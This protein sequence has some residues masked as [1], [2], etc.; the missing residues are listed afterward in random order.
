MQRIRFVPAT[1]SC[2]GEAANSLDRRWRGIPTICV[3]NLNKDWLHLLIEVQAPHGI[4][5]FRAMTAE[6]STQGMNRGS[7]PLGNTPENPLLPQYLQSDSGIEC[8]SR[9]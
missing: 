3:V 4:V 1:G 8:D 5:R 7:P 2:L 6:R 9:S